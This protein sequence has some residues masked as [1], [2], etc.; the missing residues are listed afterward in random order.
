VRLPGKE[1]TSYRWTSHAGRP[2]LA[3]ESVRSASLW[4]RKVAVA[5][6]QLGEVRFGWWVE[7][8]MADANVADAATEDAAARVLF[9]FAG[10]ESR[11]PARTRAMFDLAEVLTGE[12]P[13]YATLMYVYETAAAPGSLIVNPRSDRIRKLVLDSGP[14]HLRQW[15][16]HRRDLR[17]DFRAVFGEEPGPLVAVALMTDSDNTRSRATTWYSPPRLD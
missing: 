9:A 2:A 4:R 8:L 15:R 14:A 17:A 13:P 6:E 16:D 1:A 10:D 11:L 12:R 5:P 3:A 7:H